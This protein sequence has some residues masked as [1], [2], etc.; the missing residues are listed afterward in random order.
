M[1]HV[2]KQ[3]NVLVKKLT[4]NILF[5]ILISSCFLVSQAFGGEKELLFHA[6][7]G[8]RAALNEIKTIF[9]KK[10]PDI[11]V[12][13]SY[14]GSGYFIADITRSKQGDLFM[15]GEEFYLLQAV[16]RGFISDY[17]PQ[18]DIPAHFVTVIIV[19]KGNPKN[20]TKIEDFAR[21][22]IRVGLGNPRSCAIGIWH[23]K[24]FKK[25]G[26]WDK[27]RANAT[28]SAKCIPE[29]GNATQ[30]R[31][32]DGT[33]VWATT[34]VLY[35]RDVEIIPIEHK[36][37]GIVR[38]PVGVL[39]FARYREEARKLMDFILSEEARVI[40]HKHAYA[41]NPVIPVDKD[42]FCLDGT[43][44]KDMEY[45]VNAARAVKD[46]SFP[47]SKKTV[48]DLVKEIERQRKTVRAGD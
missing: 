27:V 40:F 17:D 42:G 6:G 4:K 48:G 29:L 39:K 45:L 3:N 7:L 18:T 13:F 28:M 31:A 1:K 9:E 11:K 35:L 41:V 5:F 25:A 14:K 24:T 34:A 46:E 32:I 30:H 15:P 19:P 12:N 44:D 2:L 8:Q 21:P 10:H 23:E 26:I 16:E 20:I 33:I 37:R 47:V 36:Y 38:L 43:T 22:G